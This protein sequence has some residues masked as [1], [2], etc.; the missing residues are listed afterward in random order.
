MT[1]NE[2]LEKKCYNNNNLVWWD[3]KCLPK[4][5]FLLIMTSIGKSVESRKFLKK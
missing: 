5:D 4:E 2:Y 3:N 1:W